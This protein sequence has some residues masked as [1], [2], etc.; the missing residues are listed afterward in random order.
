MA[1]DVEA[2]VWEALKK[3]KFP[4]MSRDIVSF[5]FVHSVKV[6]GG[7]ALVGLEIATQNEA[8][9]ASL[10]DEIDRAVAALPGVGRVEVQVQVK[11]PAGREDSAQRA[12]SQDASLIPEVRHVVAVASGKGGVGKS[13]VAANL[14]IELG[15]LGY[16]V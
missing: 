7:T 9:V 10:K 4:G 3:V 12:I 14:A 11:R 2:S 13:T 15:G 16:R 5:G 1:S 6:E 8:A